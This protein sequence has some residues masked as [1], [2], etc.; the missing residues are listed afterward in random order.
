MF[1]LLATANDCISMTETAPS[2]LSKQVG[3][4]E[5][6]TNATLTAGNPCGKIPDRGSNR[7]CIAHIY[8]ATTW[9][10]LGADSA[11][12]CWNHPARTAIDHLL[13]A[14][15]FFEFMSNGINGQ[16]IGFINMRDVSIFS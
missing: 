6:H 15:H 3:P 8:Q 7:T 9:H 10:G 5:C 2:A 16:I 14:R 13:G 12:D 1:R 11:G 4:I